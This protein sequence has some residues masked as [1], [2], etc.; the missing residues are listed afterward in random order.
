MNLT[1]AYVS[2]NFT[3]ADD[4]HGGLA[5]TEHA[6]GPAPAPA[7]PVLSPASDSGAKGDNITNFVQPALING[8]IGLIL[9]TGGKLSRVLTFTFTIAK[10]ARLEVT[11]DP[12]SRARAG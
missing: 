9:A 2:R 7:T 4:G 8:S 5:I 1:G 6:A 11:G 12:P 3:L 10:I